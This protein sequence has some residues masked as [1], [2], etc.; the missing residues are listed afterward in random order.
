MK[1]TFVAVGLIALVALAPVRATAQQIPYL[2]ELLSRSEAFYKLYNEKRRAGA[3]LS[4]LE[5]VRKKGDEAFRQ[6]NIPGIIEFLSQ[7][8]SVLQGQPWSE[9]QKFL[10]SLMVDTDRL[11]IEPNQELRVS[12]E[13]IFPTD[14][15]KAFPQPLTVTFE[16][17]ASGSVSQLSASESGAQKLSG[18]VVIAEHLTIAETS[19]N[20]S[21]RLMIPDGEYWVVASIE[22]GGEKVGE[23]RRAVYAIADF[24]VSLRQMSR[25]IAEIKSS[26]DARVKSI[27]A[28]VSAPEF[29]IQR[30]SPLIKSRG[31]DEI[32][33]IQEIDRIEATIT[34]M[35]K[36]QN[37]FSNERGE[38]ERAYQ[39]SDG[40]LVPYRVYVPKSYDEKSARP[41]VLMLHGALGDEKYFFSYL[42][43][44]ETIK[45][46]AER[47][48]YIL[49]GANGRSRFPTYSGASAED[50]FEVIKAVSRDYKIDPSRIYLMGHSTGGFGAWLIASSKP[51][52]FAAIAPISSG[53]PAQGDALKA[54]LEKVKAVPALVAHGA[55]DGIW[56]AE[57]SRA[58]VEAAQKAGMKATL[59][60]IAD[61][62]HV[63]VV[64]AAFA[65]LLDFFEKNTKPAPTK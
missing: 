50:A 32:N 16:L 27:A 62:D 5:P 35:S 52:L 28:L 64:G 43:D 60:E 55:R 37:P 19:T 44:P 1:K 2:S 14:D 42:A 51:E 56:P 23:I 61:A 53:V 10:A 36:G 3:N 4:A 7:G 57:H 46:E 8:I 18:P 9:K 20:A 49:A 58:A 6:G 48:G 30:L 11:V 54:L 12:L 65:S 17:I 38:L 39:A 33:A 24:S 22:S 47:R 15:R 29:Q 40:A 13:R 26:T 45:G 21:R 34:A 59:L 63:T 25:T 41:L 31:Q